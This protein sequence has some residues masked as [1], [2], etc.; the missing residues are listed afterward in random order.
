MSTVRYKLRVALAT[1]PTH[2]KHIEAGEESSPSCA[3]PVTLRGEVF[4]NVNR[5]EENAT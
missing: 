4:S 1:P 2:T 5:A 3:H